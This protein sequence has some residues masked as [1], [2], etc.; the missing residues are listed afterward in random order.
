MLGLWDEKED[1]AGDYVA[2]WRENGGMLYQS[3]PDV[4][5]RLKADF[6]DEYEDI[7]WQINETVLQEQISQGVKFDYSLNS[8]D[9]DGRDVEIKAIEAVQA[10]EWDRV[11]GLL[12][13][14]GDIPARMREIEMLFSSGYEYMIDY[15]SNTIHWIKP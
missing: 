13:S 9:I 5:N 8:L 14:D 6:P 2:E 12:D 7:L 15:A 3:H 1:I 11:Y 4:Y 10:R